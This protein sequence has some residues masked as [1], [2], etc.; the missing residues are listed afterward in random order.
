MAAESIQLYPESYN[1][2]ILPFIFLLSPP[3]KN[4]SFSRV[5]IVLFKFRMLNLFTLQKK[6]GRTFCNACSVLKTVIFLSEYSMDMTFLK[7]FSI[8]APPTTSSITYIFEYFPLDSIQQIIS[9]LIYLNSVALIFNIFIF[10]PNISMLIPVK[11]DFISLEYVFMHIA[12]L[13][14]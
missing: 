6:L 14:S 13:R 11:M 10:I 12:A 8:L 4:I 9:G 3:L 7:P 1:R 2:F 5:P